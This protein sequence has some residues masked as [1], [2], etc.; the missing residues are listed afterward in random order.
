MRQLLHPLLKTA[1]DWSPDPQ[2]TDHE[3]KLVIDLGR[4]LAAFCSYGT[5]EY[6][7]EQKLEGPLFLDDEGADEALP[8]VLLAN[9]GPHS[10]FYLWQTTN[11][12]AKRFL[13]SYIT[14]IGELVFL[15]FYEDASQ[16]QFVLDTPGK[17]NPDC[18][19][20]Y[21][22]ISIRLG[23]ADGCSNASVK[24]PFHRL[25]S[26]WHGRSDLDQATN[27]VS[28]ACFIGLRPF[29]NGCSNQPELTAV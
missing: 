20:D 14:D 8:R 9:L 22:M 18:A 27:F 15:C 3:E 4:Q 13:N 29:A 1:E 28:F 21:C 16:F 17:P 2:P 11:Q 12:P 5:D 24:E 23:H 10:R 26:S 19:I 7:K 25:T 6:P